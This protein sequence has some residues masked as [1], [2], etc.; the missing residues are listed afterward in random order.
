MTNSE[1]KHFKTRFWVVFILFLLLLAF[2][3]YL[4]IDTEPIVYDESR[5]PRMRRSCLG[6]PHLLPLVFLGFPIVFFGLI[7]DVIILAIT[8]K[9]SLK[10]VMM[11]IA[12]IVGFYLVTLLSYGL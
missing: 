3:L 5:H 7:L 11:S 10:K 12:L 8:K 9:I 4:A 1:N 2:G 6:P